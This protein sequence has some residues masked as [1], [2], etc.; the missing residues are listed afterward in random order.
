M[1][2]TVLVMTY[3]HAGFIAQA[4]DS[5]LGQEVNFT[6]EVVISEDCSADGTREIV[7]AYQ[8]NYPDRIRLLLSERNLHSNE[9]VV[10][11]LQAA[12]GQYIALLDGDD[13]WTSAHK[14]QK[15]VEF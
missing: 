8:K 6:Y 9:I 1:K 5:V 13:Y 14:L 4:L 7:I 15:Q 11:G 2:V 3:N 10:R 12:Q